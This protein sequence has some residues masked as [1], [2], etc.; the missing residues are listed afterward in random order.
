MRARRWLILSALAMFLLGRDAAARDFEERRFHV[1]P[2]VGGTLFDD[3]RRFLTG[4]RVTDDMYYGGR[5]NA[6]LSCLFLVEVAGGFSSVKGCCDWYDWGHVSG[7]LVWSPATPAR[8]S[9]FL[10]IGGG[11]SKSERSAGPSEELGTY[12]FAGGV[13]VKLSDALGLRLE[14]RDIL[15][16]SPDHFND[17]VLGAGLNIGLGGNVEC[18]ADEEFEEVAAIPEPAPTPEPTPC[19]DADRDGICDDVDRCPDTPL[20]M[21]V[22]QWGCP[23]PAETSPRETEMLDKGVITVRDIYFDT[24]S[25]ELQ[26]ESNQTLNELCTIFKQRPDLQIEI[27]GH[28]DSRGDEQSNQEL[29]ERRAEAVLDWFRANCA[30]A[31]L[32][33]FST[34]GYGEDRPVGSNNTE[35]GRALNRRIE[36]KVLNP[37]VLRRDR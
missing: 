21:A 31:N 10:S 16:S 2:F 26:Q 33:N 13:N 23:P 19:P 7:N 37:E 32:E 3:D 34:Q 35:R 1:V 36:F 8:V 17:I 18:L 28:A 14:A 29:T 12:E 15:A 22:D 30:E 4:G 11:W 24:G 27:S 25:S 20:G 5:V 6:R 9:P